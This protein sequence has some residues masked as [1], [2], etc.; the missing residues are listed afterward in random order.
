MTKTITDLAMTEL[1]AC[2]ATFGLMCIFHFLKK[3]G[4]KS[5]P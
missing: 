4:L 3:D 2:S 5:L 1:L